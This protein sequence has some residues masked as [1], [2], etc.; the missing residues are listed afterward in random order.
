MV[1]MET[2]AISAFRTDR[3]ALRA[4]EN[5]QLNDI[6]HSDGASSAVRTDAQHRLMDLMDRQ[7]METMLEGLLA[8]RGFRGAIV[9]I[10]GDCINALID[11]PAVTAQEASAIL[12]IICSQTDVQIGNVKI[13]PVE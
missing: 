11:A 6:I 3:D 10:N 8:V 5:A 12:D 2:K 13:I 1:T 7:E 4:M 9:S